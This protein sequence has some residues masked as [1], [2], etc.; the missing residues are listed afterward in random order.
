METVANSNMEK[1]MMSH[2]YSGASTKPK[3][4]PQPLTQ[5]LRQT[6]VFP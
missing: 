2:T 3:R 5:Y 1:Y 6:S 4:D